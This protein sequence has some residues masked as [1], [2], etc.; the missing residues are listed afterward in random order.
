MARRAPARRRRRSPSKLT[1]L[2]PCVGPKLSPVIVTGVPTGPEVGESALIEGGTVTVKLTPLLVIPLTVTA[3]LPVEAP[4]G[5]KT[6]MLV[7]LQLVGV[8]VVPLKLTVLA[9][10]WRRS[11]CR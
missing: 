1:V 5:T 10:V 11:S 9:P 4:L 6:T 8:A 3:T 7:S 2:V